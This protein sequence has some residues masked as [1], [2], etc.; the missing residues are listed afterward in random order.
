MSQ[1]DK[2]MQFI[3]WLNKAKDFNKANKGN[4]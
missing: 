4:K 1:Q 3:Y 2:L